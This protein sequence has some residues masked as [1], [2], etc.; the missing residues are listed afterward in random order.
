MERN[1]LQVNAL[2]VDC[3]DA[4]PSC[5]TTE[6][7]VVESKKSKKSK[8]STLFEPVTEDEKPVVQPEASSAELKTSKSKKRPKSSALISDDEV[9]SGSEPSS[10]ASPLK[11][12]YTEAEF[13]ARLKEAVAKE[14]AKLAKKSSTSFGKSKKS[15]EQEGEKVVSTTGFNKPHRLSKALAAVCGEEIVRLPP[16]SSPSGLITSSCRDRK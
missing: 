13:Q 3:F 12:M 8:T 2:I 16:S 1:K 7:I 5:P 9:E 15:G 6:P 4:V 14:M 10:S 11:R